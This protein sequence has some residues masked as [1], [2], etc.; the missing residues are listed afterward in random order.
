MVTL[1][2]ESRLNGTIVGGWY[3][4]QVATGREILE[5]AQY[6]VLIATAQGNPFTTKGLECCYHLTWID[7][8][9]CVEKLVSK[10]DMLQ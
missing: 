7:T 5:P 9:I 1:L 6:A 3:G 2:E 4:V 8:Y 10:H